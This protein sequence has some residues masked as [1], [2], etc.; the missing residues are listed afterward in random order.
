MILKGFPIPPT[1]NRLLMPAR[2]RLVKTSDARAYD[3]KVDVFKMINRRKIEALKNQLSKLETKILK[4]EF[5]FVL[6]K[7]RLIGQKG[8]LKKL[9]TSNRLKQCQDHLAKIIEIDDCQY[10]DTP[11]KKVTCEDVK[12]EQVIILIKETILERFEDLT[13]DV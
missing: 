7:K 4:V 5:I 8:Q 12:D 13:F 2:G 6:H 10:V 3:T 11:I 9:D 1:S